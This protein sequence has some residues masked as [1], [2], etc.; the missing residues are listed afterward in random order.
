MK[1]SLLALAAL[2]AFASGAMAQ[3]SVTIY[4]I[5]DLGLVYQ[6]RADQTAETGLTVGQTALGGVGAT[7]KGSV[8]QA[9]KSRLGFRGVEDLGGGYQAKFKLEH[10]LLPDTGA[11]NTAGGN[12]FWDMSVVSLVTPIGE[13]GL[14]RDYMPAF[15]LQYLQDPWLNQGI[16]EVGGTVSYAFASYIGAA[17]GARINNAAFYTMQAN[18]FT[19]Q[20]A[21]SAKED[22][23]AG[24]GNAGAK[25]RY[26]IGVQYAAGPLFLGVAYDQSEQTVGAD[27]NLLIVG[28]AYDF[29]FVK[30]RLTYARAD[31]GTTNPSSITLAATVPVST[32]LIKAGFASFDADNALDLKSSKVSIGYEHTMSKRTAIYTDLTSGKVKANGFNFKGVTGVDVGIRHMF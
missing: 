28:G 8:A 21:V 17:R 2:G 14:G 23:S 9:T 29:G 12:N 19:A 1:K 15:Y 27:N 4:G 10:R 18:G 13:F 30:P 20:L 16:A 31:M 24:A 6:N 7:A 22:G 25:N 32:G 3:S 26:G 11:I 5:V